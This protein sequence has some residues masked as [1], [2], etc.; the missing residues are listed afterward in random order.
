MTDRPTVDELRADLAD[1]TD[2]LRGLLDV[3]AAGF[4]DRPTPAAGWAIRDQVS[5]LTYFDQ[6]ALIALTEPDRFRR[7]SAALTERFVDE[8][9]ARDRARPSGELLAG[10][11]KARAELLAAY[12]GRT[13][14][15]RIPWYGPDMSL[16]SSITARLMETWAHGEDVADALGVER[17]PTRRLRHVA[18]LGVSTRAFAYAVHGREQPAAPIRIELAGPDGDLWAWGPDDAPDSVRGPALDFCLAVAQR[19]HLDDLALRIAGPAAREWMAIA[20]IFAGAPGAGRAP[21]A[22]HP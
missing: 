5:H 2:S 21:R 22:A 12:E 6:Q 14:R 11:D 19:R 16:A 4:W 1:E 3:G 18:H 8:Q 9:A 13:A 10:F 15:E 7:E 17:A 20:Q